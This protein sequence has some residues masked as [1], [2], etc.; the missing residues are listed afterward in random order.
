[1]HI[2]IKN[3]KTF[4]NYIIEYILNENNFLRYIKNE[5]LIEFSPSEDNYAVLYKNL[6]K[7][8]DEEF[9]DIEIDE[10]D[11]L[12]NIIIDEAKN[13]ETGDSKKFKI[14]L[15]KVGRIGEYINHLILSDYCGFSCI[16]PKVALTTNL[17]MSVFGIDQLFFDENEKILLFGETKVSKN[18]NN[19]ITLINKSL[20]NYEEQI[21]KEF[22]LVLSESLIGKNQSFKVF[23]K[24]IDTCISFDEFVNKIGLEKIGIPL[25]IAHGKEIDGGKILKSLSKIKKK[26]IL[27]LKTFYIV[28]SLPIISKKDFI[29]ELTKEIKKKLD[30]YESKKLYM[31]K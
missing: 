24:V 19:G 5:T 17:N 23:Q 26:K 25:F 11:I 10:D 31:S 8:I 15:S 14:R 30:Y 1:M 2:N 29:V 28:I 7:Y 27:G 21:K 3:K 16:I 9:L 13:V 18:I 22:D 6:L 4:F 12:K 20:E